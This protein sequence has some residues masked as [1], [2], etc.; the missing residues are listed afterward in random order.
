MYLLRSY[1]HPNAYLDFGCYR[2]LLLFWKDHYLA[3][4]KDCSGLE[5]T[6]RIKFEEWNSIVEKL[7]DADSSKATSLSH[8][9]DDE[10]DEDDEFS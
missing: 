6:S 5:R 7:L 8:Y 2:D 1:R 10:D 4:D 3:K 9:I